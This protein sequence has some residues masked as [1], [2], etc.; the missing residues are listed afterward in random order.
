ML[1]ND[2]LMNFNFKPVEEKN[3]NI[4][5]AVNNQ[6]HNFTK[7]WFSCH[8]PIWQEILFTL[9]PE[10]ILEIGS[11]E[12]KSTCFLIDTLSKLNESEIHCIDSWEGGIEHQKRLDNMS[13]VEER[14]VH[15]I[16]TSLAGAHFKTTL[17]THKGFSCDQLPKLLAEGKKGYFDFIYIDGSH[18]APDVLLDAILSFQLLRVGGVMV[19]DDY[20]WHMCEAPK[21]D[22]ISH[23]KIAIDA[24]TNIFCRKMNIFMYKP[25]YQLYIE[26]VSD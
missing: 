18:N 20:L 5:Q 3:E 13:D 19:F 8:E 9:R 7:D 10:R 16:R 4:F 1:F 26:K 11:Y 22:P 6:T 23:P 21:K 17:M 15:N 14:F 25:L 24:F 12:G 2:Q